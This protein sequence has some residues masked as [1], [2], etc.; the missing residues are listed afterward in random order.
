MIQSE[1]QSIIARA[2]VR[3]RLE[4]AVVALT[5]STKHS[6]E[7][8]VERLAKKAAAAKRPVPAR[9]TRSVAAVRN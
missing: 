2:Q 5:D 9:A 8:A 3:G 1:Q 7:V 6:I 4:T